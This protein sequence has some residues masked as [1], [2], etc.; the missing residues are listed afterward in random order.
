VTLDWCW[1]ITVEWCCYKTRHW[2]RRCCNTS[3][4]AS[5]LGVLQDVLLCKC[6]K[7]PCR[8]TVLCHKKPCRATVHTSYRSKLPNSCQL[9]TRGH[10]W[11]LAYCPPDC[12]KP[13]LSLF[14]LYMCVE[15]WCFC[16]P[17]HG[18]SVAGHPFSLR[19]RVAG[20]AVRHHVVAIVCSWLFCLDIM[21]A[22]ESLA[23]LSW[24]L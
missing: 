20:H 23:F 6:H 7:K 21:R 9:W 18:L 14:F 5:R 13:S 8:A 17:A 1:C 15:R 12:V 22:R 3:C 10:R 4:C 24:T 16:N 11:D 2:T 19:V